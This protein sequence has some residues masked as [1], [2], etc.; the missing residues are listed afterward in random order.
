MDLI[1]I[2]KIQKRH[3]KKGLREAF[4][5]PAMGLSTPTGKVLIPNPAGKEALLFESLEEAEAAIRKAGFDYEY[6]GKATYLF[7]KTAFRKAD[8]PV[9][10]LDTAIP[11]LLSRLQDREPAVLANSAAAL[12]MLRASQAIEPLLGILGHDDPAVRKSASD[13]LARLAPGSIAGL[14]RAYEQ[15]LASKQ[16][17]VPYV[18]LTVLTAFAEMLQIGQGAPVLEQCL[19]VIIQGLEDESWLVRAQ[20]ALVVGQLAAFRE[21]NEQRY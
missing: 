16:A 19:P 12:G 13:A 5:V 6:E 7:E 8:Q 1:H 9:Q 10:S 15:A 20:A 3:P 18:R 14:N 4:A 11:I 21:A 2:K 17:N